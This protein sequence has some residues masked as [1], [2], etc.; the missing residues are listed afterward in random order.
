MSKARD[1]ANNWAADITAVSAGVGITGGG[2]SGAVTVTNEMATTIDAK[3][4]L[5]VGSGADA[6]V[7]VPVGSNNQV[8]TADSATTSG[9]KWATAD[10]LP[11]QTGNSGKYLTTNGTTASWGTVNQPLTW[12]QRRNPTTSAGFAVIEYN[13]SNLYVA[14]GSNG[15]LATSPDGITWTDRTSGFGSDKIYS[16]RYGNGLWVAVGT[17]GKITTSTDGVTWTA[18]TSNMGTNIIYDVIY[19]N[20]T[21]VAVGDGGGTTNTGGITYSTD[22]IT[23]T[24]KS[25]SVAIEPNYFGVAWNGTNWIVGTYTNGSNNM[26]Y[27]STPSGTWTVGQAL[28]K[29]INRIWYDGTRTIYIYSDDTISFT[30]NTSGLSPTLY[31]QQTVQ[32]ASG[33]IF[34]HY[35][36]SGNLYWA[37]IILQSMGT[38]PSSNFAT[39][40]RNYGFAITYM[41]ADGNI[42]NQSQALF[43]GANGYIIADSPGRIYT[44][45]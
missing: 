15:I 25:Q 42:E 40:V 16:V 38:T 6:F 43:V 21:W 7:R 24:R 39:N 44:S 2:T 10:A 27:A 18:R 35:L 31:T 11:S 4:D 14:A 34:R 36:Y 32:S 41:N 17:N 19:A 3:G 1:L 30:T 45:F 13:G 22:G 29:D 9:V 20:S 12:T 28:N 37:G 33:G 5:V 23:W 8:L 26:I